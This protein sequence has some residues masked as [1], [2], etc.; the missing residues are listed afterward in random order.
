MGQQ[1]LLGQEVGITWPKG[2]LKRGP[3]RRRRTGYTSFEVVDLRLKLI[4]PVL[5]APSS[6]LQLADG[7][8]FAKLD[9]RL[10]VGVS[11]AGGLSGVSAA[12]SELHHFALAHPCGRDL[13]ECAEPSQH[14]IFDRIAA[15]DL[16]FGLN[17]VQRRTPGVLREHRFR[18]SKLDQNIGMGRV[19]RGLEQGSHQCN[20]PRCHGN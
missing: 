12:A 15:E 6:R 4:D 10:C 18:R 8:G 17:G 2:D 20:E 11:D 13:G 1:G 7:L 14:P 5:D 16:D 19:D 9:V 3:I